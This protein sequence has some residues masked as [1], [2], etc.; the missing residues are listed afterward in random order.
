MRQLKLND[1][2][3]PVTDLGEDFSDSMAPW[4]WL[5]PPK[6]LPL[7]ITAMGDLFVTVE[8]EVW[9]LD[10]EGGRFSRVSADRE[11]WKKLMR[12][13]GP[14]FDWLRPDLVSMLLDD[15]RSLGAGEVFSPLVPVVLGGSRTADNYVGS[16]WRAH[17]NFLG[18]V[19]DK[20]RGLP[21][22]ERIQLVFDPF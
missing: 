11:G 5:V 1:L 16:Q 13:P 12:D 21:F 19:H 10:M 15:G 4:S 20:I 7:M 22:G 8:G 6:A 14:T 18:Q 2:L 3:A 17:M 9:F